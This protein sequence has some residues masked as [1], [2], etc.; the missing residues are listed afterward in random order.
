ML[1]NQNVVKVVCVS[2]I[3]AAFQFPERMRLEE[4][5]QEHMR[6]VSQGE[7][8][9]GRNKNPHTGYLARKVGGEAII[10]GLR[11]LLRKRKK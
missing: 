5:R 1:E 4:T 8:R 11:V 10:L 7:E 3:S 6:D 2:G 9:E